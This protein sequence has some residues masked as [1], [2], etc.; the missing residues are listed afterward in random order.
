MIKKNFKYNEIYNTDA[1]D[2]LKII[3]DKSIDL[4]FFD[5][6]IMSVK[7]MENIKIIYL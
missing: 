6:R 5:P 3:P 4:T 2:L 1:L 7:I